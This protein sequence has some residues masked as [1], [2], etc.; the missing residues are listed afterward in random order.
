MTDYAAAREAMVEGQVRANDV[1]DRDLQA[2]MRTIPRELF[3]PKSARALAYSDLETPL[4]D[5]RVM[6]APRDFA[7]LTYALDVRPEHAVLDVACGRG[8]SS[9]VLARLAEGVV[10]LEPDPDLAAKA[11]DLL[12]KV[13]ADNAVV[14]TGDPASGVPKQGPFD[15]IFVNGAV[16]VVPDAWL[17]QL[18]D[19]GRLGVIVR[20]GPIG[21]AR[22]YTRHD[23]AVGERTVFDSGASLLP[24]LRQARAFEF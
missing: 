14:V 3:A 10:G 12:A 15:V 7:K 23:G 22:I 16:E 5:G 9:A 17:E 11:T 24:G 6:M 18:S 21:K 8:Y 19:G 1:P 20:E 2:A 13:G 4:A